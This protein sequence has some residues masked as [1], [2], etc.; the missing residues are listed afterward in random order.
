[1]QGPVASA[2]GHL[3]GE[4]VNLEVVRPPSFGS[5]VQFN[6]INIPIDAQVSPKIKAKIWANEFGS[7]LNPAMWA[8]HDTS[9]HWRRVK[10]RCQNFHWSHL[11]RANPYIISM[12]GHQPS[13][14]LLGSTPVNSHIKQNEWSKANPDQEKIR[15]R[16]ILNF[17]RWRRIMNAQ[18]PRLWR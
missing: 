11:L 5:P 7:L 18:L 14:F 9:F 13:R 12:C 2:L 17:P 8:K 3:T 4:R 16:M 6:S 1:M 10:V 15:R